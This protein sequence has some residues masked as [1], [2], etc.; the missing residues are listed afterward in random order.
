MGAYRSH[1]AAKTF[2]PGVDGIAAC[3]GRKKIAM[4]K[5]PA[6]IKTT[7]PN[8]LSL[9]H[10]VAH[11]VVLESKKAISEKGFFSI[12]LS[13]GS[14]P[15]LLYALLAQAPYRDNIDWKKTYVAF[16]DERFVPHSSNE[17]NF[18]MANEALLKKIPLPR[19]N[20]LAVKTKGITPVA[21]AKAYELEITAFIS[22]KQPFD[23]VLLGIGE[24]GHT[25]SIFPG[26]AL[27]SKR[28]RVASVFV[29]E[30]NMERISFTLPFINQAKNVA[31]LVAGAG[32][33]KIVREIFSKKKSALP[34]A[35]V[36]ARE[37]TYWFLDELSN[38][39]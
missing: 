16:G 39:G 29:I 27:I 31:F 10:A 34:A 8:Q 7:W 25:A 37:T 24:E 5:Q 20:I 15:A 17:S 28:N 13:G 12:A 23:L 38:G 33:A 30:K 4:T 6:V 22:A 2:R 36:A 21:S 3:A 1:N 32:K 9:A 18:K 14:T 19:K 26:S 35:L 11:L